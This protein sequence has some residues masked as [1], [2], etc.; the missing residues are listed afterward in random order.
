VKMAVVVS[1]L[2]D[3]GSWAMTEN[4][5]VRNHSQ[6]TADEARE[7]VLTFRSH[8]LC[9]ISGGASEGADGI[10]KLRDLLRSAPGDALCDGCLASACAVSLIAM[11]LWTVALRRAEPDEFQQAS[12]CASCRRIVP[13]IIY[14][15]QRG[16]MPRVA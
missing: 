5:R 7:L 4:L 8:R 2:L 9:K 6:R 11:R 16:G 15:P 12:S 1:D 13:S 14:T 10:V 3:E